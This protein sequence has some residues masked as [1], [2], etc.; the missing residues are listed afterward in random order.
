MSTRINYAA[1][2]RAA[3]I[4]AVLCFLYFPLATFGQDDRAVCSA[5]IAFT[6]AKP[7]VNAADVVILNLFSTV[8][9]PD[10]EC[11]AAEI[12]VTATFFDIDENLI[13]SGTIA[14]MDQ[15]MNVMST[16]LEIRPLNPLEFVRVINPRRPPAKRLFCNNLEG[17]A[18]VGSTQIAAANSLRLH[19]T[20]LPRSGGVATAEAR[21]TLRVPA[22]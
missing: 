13:C 21:M 14:L 6:N 3:G 10:R 12:H 16:N 20:I 5:E 7:V 17:N 22:R 15:S 11:F 2:R 18:E 19:A 8:S 1:T 4:L 9:N